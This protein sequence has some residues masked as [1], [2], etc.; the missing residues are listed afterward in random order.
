MHNRG[1]EATFFA[2]AFTLHERIA[3]GGQGMVTAHAAQNRS[4]KCFLVRNCFPT[5]CRYA[6]VACPLDA[7]CDEPGYED[8][9]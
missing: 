9:R 2:A 3:R 5:F 7:G 4:E 8:T 6:A 1:G